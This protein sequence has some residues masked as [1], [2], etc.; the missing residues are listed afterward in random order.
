MARAGMLRS[1]TRGAC[2]RAPRRR[3]RR[4]VT[5]GINERY[6]ESD[7]EDMARAIRKVSVGLAAGGARA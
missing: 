1:S 2:A 5:L 3:S 6:A 4:M 7:V